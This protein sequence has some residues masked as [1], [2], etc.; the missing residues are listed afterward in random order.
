MGFT[1]L[2]VSIFYL[3]HYIKTYFLI[4]V[5]PVASMINTTIASDVYTGAEPVEILNI[6]GASS[7][8]SSVITLLFGV[9]STSGVFES[10]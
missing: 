4:N 6:T 8:S 3:F 1:S 2:Q 9:E 5:I 10:F 7:I